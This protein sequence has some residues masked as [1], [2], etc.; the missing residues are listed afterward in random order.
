MFPSHIKYKAR[1]SV[2]TTLIHY[3]ARS[4]TVR[5]EQEIKYI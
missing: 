5:Q 2:L 4:S 1:M 3:C